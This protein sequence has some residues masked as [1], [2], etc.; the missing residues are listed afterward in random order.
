MSSDA[1]ARI[2]AL[3]HPQIARTLRARLEKRQIELAAQLAT[4]NAEDYPDY[5]QRVGHIR[6][7]KDAIDLCATI[8]AEYQQG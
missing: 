5:R 3:D 1:G 2:F 6:G 7:L 8:E 4:G